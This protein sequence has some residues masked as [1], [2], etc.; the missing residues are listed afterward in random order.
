MLLD[1][2]RGL[3]PSTAEI[4][5]HL[6]RLQRNGADLPEGWEHWPSELRA[7]ERDGQVKIEGE[8]W[9]TFVPQKPRPQQM[10]MF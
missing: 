9:W 6:A 1:L 7:M 5:D 8:G 3:D 10:G 4:A 2:I